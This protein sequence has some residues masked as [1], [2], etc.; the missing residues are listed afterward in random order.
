MNEIEVIRT[1]PLAE[2][3]FDQA[4]SV[5]PLVVELKDMAVQELNRKIHESVPEAANLIIQGL[6]FTAKRNAIVFEISKDGKKM[7]DSGKAI[8]SFDKSGKLLPHIKSSETGKIIEQFR[9]AKFPLAS[10]LASLST[11]IVSAAHI[12]S[13]ADISRK[14]D[15]IQE[16]VSFLVAAR[17]IDQM[18]DLRSIYENIREL[19]SLEKTREVE[20]D[21]KK[22]IRHLSKLR[23]TWVGEVEYHLN[24]LSYE[25]SYESKNWL[26]KLFS[27]KKT[28]DD[29]ISTKLTPFTAEL[30]LIDFTIV[31]ELLIYEYCGLSNHLTEVRMEDEVK[32]IEKIRDLLLDKAS[33]LTED[34]VDVDIVVQG[35]DDL[36]KK[37]ECFVGD[38]QPHIDIDTDDIKRLAK[39]KN[40]GRNDVCPCGSFAK[41]KNCCLN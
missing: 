40:I 28:V 19:L 17:K 23:Y 13:G 29:K 36:I 16:G 38:F 26:Q 34:S 14:L 18:A 39:K 3:P 15:R 33:L 10:K 27:R 37:F 24:Q 6:D 1:H 12:V 8:L 32:N 21:L 22:E 30:Q 41:Y 2:L 31:L 9:G 25:D 5:Y 7:L 4:I 11:I 35:F 20:R